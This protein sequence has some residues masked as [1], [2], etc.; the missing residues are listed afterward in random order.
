MTEHTHHHEQHH[1]KSHVS[2][3]LQRTIV[4]GNIGIGIAEALTAGS[5]S[6]VWSDFGHNIADA[7]V[8]NEQLN[9][10]REPDSPKAT[11]YKRRKTMYTIL[12]VSSAAL[13]IKSGVDL[14]WDND[15]TADPLAIYTAGASVVFN[16]GIGIARYRQMRQ[17][18]RERR[19]HSHHD[20]DVNKHL[21]VDSA[22]AGLA[23][24]GAVAG[25]STLGPIAGIVSGMIGA[26]LFFPSEK[27]LRHSYHAHG[28]EDKHTHEH[29]HH[30]LTEQLPQQGV[31]LNF[32]EKPATVKDMSELAP[33]T[34]PT[35]ERRPQ[36][37]ARILETNNPKL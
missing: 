22:S 18:Q 28:E 20:H 26:K 2:K 1:P 24:V 37:E 32:S 33:I 36:H 4:G 5:A 7:Y 10:V 13:A 27:N 29:V 19:T 35:M 8:Y 15:T 16:G 6:A 11:N 21:A 31:L 9:N 3:V 12:S 14:A 34:E 30:D 23:F 17:Q 25:A